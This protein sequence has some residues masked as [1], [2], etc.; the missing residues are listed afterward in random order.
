MRRKTN[1]DFAPE[2]TKTVMKTTH[3]VLNLAKAHNVLIAGADN[4]GISAILDSLVRSLRDA[5]SSYGLRFV[6][7]TPESAKAELEALNMEMDERLRETASTRPPV[8]V[9]IKDFDTLTVPSDTRQEE[10]ERAGEFYRLILR[11]AIKGGRAQIRLVVTTQSLSPD[12]ITMLIKVNFPTRIAVR[13]CSSHDS[14]LILDSP[15]AEDL[16]GDGD[17]LLDFMG[18]I[19]PFTGGEFV[20]E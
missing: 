15:G 19:E 8:F 1:I 9:I 4:Q 20:M 5:E 18:R 7:I 6:S 13:T 17:C 2:I 14:R 10:I 3:P 16:T 11:L 12:A